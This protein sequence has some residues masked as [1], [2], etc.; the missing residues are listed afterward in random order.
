MSPETPIVA[1]EP[2]DPSAIHPDA[3]AFVTAERDG[4][5]LT[6]RR[7]SGAR[8][9]SPRH[10]ADDVAGGGRSPR[11]HG[12]AAHPGGV[13]AI[14]RGAVD[15]SPETAPQLILRNPTQ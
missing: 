7:A 14:A 11:G 3:K 6:A 4:G 2:V 13:P 5:K 12:V 8:T 9:A 15:R 10:V 1:Y